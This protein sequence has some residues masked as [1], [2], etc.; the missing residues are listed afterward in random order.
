MFSLEC[1]KCCNSLVPDELLTIDE[2]MKDMSY[3]LDDIGELQEA[4]IQ[5]YLV[6]RCNFCGNVKRFTYK[7]WEKLFRFKIAKI[8]M[9]LKKDKC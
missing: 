2:Y 1:D 4:S 3:I 6:Y 8:V 9:Q 7:E 5:Q